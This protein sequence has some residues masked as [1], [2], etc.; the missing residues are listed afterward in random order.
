MDHPQSAQ[1]TLDRPTSN[2]I[3]RHNFSGH[4]LAM[5][6]V[7][8]ITG[9]LGVLLFGALLALVV[10]QPNV[11]ERSALSFVKKEVTQE[12][13]ERYPDLANHPVGS[14]VKEGLGR[15]SKQL[16][17]QRDDLNTLAASDYPEVWGPI[18]ESF[19]TCGSPS[20]EGT[21]ARIAAIRA[22]LKARAE[23]IGIN[24][25]QVIEFMQGQYKATVDALRG[26]LMIFL[27]VNALAFIAVLGATF[28]P[29]E[30]RHAVV[31]PAALLVVATILSV[32]AYVF[33][34]DWFY[35]ILFRNYV[36]IWYGVGLLFVF[37]FLA[38]IVINRARVTLK[39]LANLPSV[40]QIP[41][42]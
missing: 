13:L 35:A 8:R 23:A 40:L 3:D 5:T 1:S 17:I 30:R 33:G 36:G 6:F 26:D 12:V 19:C 39:L 24:Q 9:F 27:S 7:L 16:G 29:R 25:A 21:Q 4:S 14:V 28:V 2:P 37:G 22:G 15:L 42:C 41:S 34:T 18:I 38:D 32:I 31:V 10:S 20:P 11:F